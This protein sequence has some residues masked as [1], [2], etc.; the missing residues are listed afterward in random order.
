MIDDCGELA[1]GEDDGA[2]LADDGTG[3]IYPDWFEDSNLDVNEVRVNLMQTFCTTTTR[4]S[5]YFKYG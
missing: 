4:C 2:T 5:G 3:D 1:P